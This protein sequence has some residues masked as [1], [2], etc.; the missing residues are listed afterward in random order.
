MHRHHHKQKSKNIK[1][2]IYR[3]IQK[4]K[5]NQIIDKLKR[6]QRLK[7]SN[8]AQKENISQNELDEIKRLSDFSTKIKKKLVQLRNIETTGLKRSDLIYILMRSQKH[9]KEAEY[10]SYLQADLINEIKSKT[11]EIRKLIIELGMMIN[12]SDSDIVTKRLDEID[13]KKT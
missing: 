9:H 13:K 12:K 6:L 7:R 5:T 10:L 4:R 8:L 3:N 11:N 1:E 2:E